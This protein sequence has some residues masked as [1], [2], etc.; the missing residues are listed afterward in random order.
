MAL[1]LHRGGEAT[2]TLPPV[3]SLQIS[4]STEPAHLQACRAAGLRDATGLI[5]WRRSETLFDLAVVLSPDEPL[6]GARRAFFVGMLA[7]AEAVGAHA[8]PEIPVLF[9]WPDTI[10]FD[11]ARLGGGRLDWP[12]TCGEDEIP[13][14]LVFSGTLIASKA[15][16]GDPGLTPG[17]TSFDEEGF[18]LD[19]G[20]GP[21][22]ESF[23]RHLMKGFAQWHEEGFAALERRYLSRLVPGDAAGRI[24]RDGA[25]IDATGAVHALEAGL[26]RHAWCDPRNGDPLL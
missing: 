13:A 5:V 23:A 20:P 19:D 6:A 18:A 8:P 14:W 7:L 17:S 1:G 22:V 10:R 26:A 9:D 2:L 25:W 3:F 16:A 11:G 12:E 15:H 24:A 4:A 21:I